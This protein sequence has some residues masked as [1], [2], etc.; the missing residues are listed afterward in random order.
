[1]NVREW[2]R[3]NK[4]V[5]P[6]FLS[7]IF[8]SFH[9]AIIMYVNAPFISSLS[10]E[11]TVGLIFLVSSIISFMIYNAFPWLLQKFGN[12]R[13]AILTGFVGIIC[14]LLLI[15][16]SNH[17]VLLASILVYL[18]TIQTLSLNLDLFLE[19]LISIEELTGRIRA[20]F[21]TITN[22]AIV[23]SPLILSIL[24][25]DQNYQPAYL[26]SLGALVISL[27]FIA[28]EFKTSNSNP[29]LAP[30]SWKQKV[31]EIKNDRNI[32]L[33]F[34]CQLILR[35]FYA[36]MV[37]YLA[38]YLIN[39]IGFSWQE[40]G[41]IYTIM[42][43]PFV[44]FELP[45]AKLAD[46]SVGEKEILIFGLIIAGFSTLIIPQINIGSVALWA[47]ILFI[48]RTGASAIEIATESYF[49]KHVD[50]SNSEII[51]EFRMLRPLAYIIT[52]AIASVIIL[53]TSIGWSFYVLALVLFGTVLLAKDLLDTR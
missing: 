6:L 27:I 14:L 45:L 47:A 40:V 3:S 53:L 25:V 1:M 23:I 5:Y 44:L 16:S 29:S 50:E 21:L 20:I 36:W 19:S 28:T 52:A 46:S 22:F 41:I 7:N 39:T 42:L 26:L 43:L 15:I 11:K 32:L 34:I 30:H 38:I 18:S 13:L 12:Y 2:S 24:I 9:S 4:L 48:S 49:F 31:L 8:L 35:V 10:S 37:M 17:L 51:S 33:I